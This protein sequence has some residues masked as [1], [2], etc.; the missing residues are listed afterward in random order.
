MRTKQLAAAFLVALV[1]LQAG[2]AQVRRTT[3]ADPSACQI[4]MQSIER[5]FEV[6]GKRLDGLAELARLGT[7][8]DRQKIAEIRNR[9]GPRLDALHD[10][11]SALISDIDFTCDECVVRACLRIRSTLVEIRDKL[12]V[13]IRDLANAEMNIREKIAT[14]KRVG[15][16][17]R[18]TDRM[19]F[20]AAKLAKKTDNGEDAFPGLRR[21]FELQEQAKQ[22]LA[23]GRLEVAMK[24]TIRARDLI[25]RTIKAALDSA[26]VAAVRERV[27]EYWKQTNKMIKRIERYIDPSAN[28]KAARLIEM[29]KKEQE[30]AR[31][32]AETHPYR[33]LRH[34]RAARRIV[35][36]LIRFHQRAKR[37]DVR[38]ER[39]EERLENAKEIVEE[40]GNEKAEEIL[41]RGIS[42]YEKGVELC[43]QGDAAKATAQFDI[44][45]K[46]VA[47]AVDIAKGN[48]PRTKALEREI[49]KTALIVKRAGEIAETDNQKE[50][51]EKAEE[52]VEQAKENIEN[53][54][55]CLK[56]LDKATDIAFKVIEKARRTDKKEDKE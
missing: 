27:V 49:R 24:M 53:P 1:A 51:V 32:L 25:G 37:C 18:V 34:A 43:Q 3:E 16:A 33:A 13:S 31:E 28:P 12:G 15:R 26:D 22:A 30:R 17:I 20:R 50:S 41:E 7:D 44:A 52:L 38:A 29:A 21:A 8:I 14:A 9:F 55:T 5:A 48:T 11:Y 46:L 19:L 47:K 36:E 35:S 42:H 54:K 10:Q 6:A 4:L 56:L 2:F 23:S 39:L 45:V 40:S